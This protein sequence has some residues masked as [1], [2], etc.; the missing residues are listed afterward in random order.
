MPL[1]GCK[2]M[3]GQATPGRQ[4]YGHSGIG[5]PYFQCLARFQLPH[6]FGYFI[7][8]AIGTSYVTR[9]IKIVGP[10]AGLRPIPDRHFTIEFIESNN[11]L[12]FIGG[13]ASAEVNAYCAIICRAA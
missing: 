13:F 2:L 5:R 7:N 3:P 9:I 10:E 12:G 11:P 4:V 6:Q 1:L 8:R